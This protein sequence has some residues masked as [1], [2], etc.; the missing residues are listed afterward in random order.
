MGKNIHRKLRAAISLAF[1]AGLQLPL[2]VKYWTRQQ[3][4]M[5]VMSGGVLR[6]K[7][8]SMPDERLLAN[9]SMSKEEVVHS[10]AQAAEW[11]AGADA[12]LIGSG[13]GMGVDA[14]LGT[15]RGGKKGVWDGLEAVGLAYEE[16]CEPRWFDEV[17]GEPRLA[18]GFWNHCHNA[19]QEIMMVVNLARAFGWYFFERMCYA[20]FREDIRDLA[21][22]TTDKAG[23]GQHLARPLE[24]IGSFEGVLD[25][26]VTV[27]FNFDRTDDGFA[28]NTW[29]DQV[30][31]VVLGMTLLTSFFFLMTSKLGTERPLERIWVPD[32][33]LSLK[34]PR[35]WFAM[36]ALQLAQAIT[37]KLLVQV[38][39][40]PM[41]TELDISKA[42]TEGK[43]FEMNFREALRVPFIRDD[44]NTQN[45]QKLGG[46]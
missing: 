4:E 34:W 46:R 11:L 16:I 43:E 9:A 14:G 17:T 25:G 23:R 6:P 38:V 35:I 33:N 2:E 36:H 1:S 39:R 40:I 37:T 7:N 10:L 29:H 3:L 5:F 20:L 30:L 8:C 31:C 41:P 12:L 19:Y 24:V 28:R 13:A 45:G 18:W 44:P 21:S 27:Y 15:F 26:F 42:A 22:L 32:T